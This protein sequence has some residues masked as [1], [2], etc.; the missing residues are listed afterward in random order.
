M[1]E[2]THTLGLQVQGWNFK[3]ENNS[4]ILEK[5]HALF[6][7]LH[8]NV[9]RNCITN[10]GWGTYGL[11]QQSCYSSTWENG[12]TATETGRY[13]QRAKG[14]ACLLSGALSQKERIFVIIPNRKIQRAL[15]RYDM[16]QCCCESFLVVGLFYFCLEPEVT[17]WSDHLSEKLTEALFN[18]HQKDS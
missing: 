7:P 6:F 13:A 18:P 8:D 14:L 17:F 5:K 11:G 12:R 2:W 9:N 16:E 1:L 15:R 10:S 4:G 3:E